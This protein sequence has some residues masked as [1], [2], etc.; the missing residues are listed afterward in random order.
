MKREVVLILTVVL[1]FALISQIYADEQTQVEQAYTC[2]S[3]RINQTGCSALSFEERA[4]SALASGECRSE[5]SADNS[6]NECW[7]KSGCTVKSTALAILALNSRV[8]TTKAE[9][10]LL[11]RTGTP[12]GIDW[13]LEIE[14]NDNSASSC[15]ITYPG[16]SPY[17]IKINQDKTIDKGAGNLLKRTPDHY[18]LQISPALYNKDI[19]ITCTDHSF[20]TTLLFK[21]SSYPTVHV[22]EQVHGAGKGGTTFERVESYCFVQGNSCTYEGSLWAALVLKSLGQDNPNSDISSFL[23]YLITMKDDPGNAIYIP[24]SFLYYLTAKFQEQLLI[25]QRVGGY[26][27]ESGNRYYDTALALLPFVY[28][29]SITAK[30]NAKTWLLANQQKTGCWNYG[31]I[32]DTAF[33]LF[34]IWP[35]D[36]SPILPVGVCE[37]DYDCPDISCQVASCSNEE[38]YYSDAGCEDYDGCCGQGCTNSNDNDC[39]SIACTNNSQCVDAGDPYSPNYCSGD[40]VYREAYTYHCDTSAHECAQTSNEEFVEACTDG[41][42]AGECNGGEEPECTT[43]LFGLSDS[44]PT[45]QECVEGKCV[46]KG[47]EDC[48]SGGDSACP[49]TQ[50][51][52]DYCSDDTT[53][54]RTAYSYS[55]DTSSG[56]CNAET[57]EEFVQTCNT[58]EICDGG[59]CVPNTQCECSLF[60]WCD[61]GY[62][63]DNCMCLPDNVSVECEDDSWCP[64]TDYG[65]DYCSDDSTAV[66]RSAHSYSCDTG[67]GKCVENVDEELVSTCIADSEICDN[68]ECITNQDV[69]SFWNWCDSGYHCDNGVCVPDGTNVDCEV[70]RDCPATYDGGDYCFDDQNVYKSVHSYSCDTSVGKCVEDVN[71]ELVSTCTADEYCDEGTAS[72][73]TEGTTCSIFNWCDSGFHCDSGICVPDGECEVDGDCPAQD[74][75]DSTC[76]SGTCLYEYFG[77][78][79]NDLCCNPGCNYTKDNDCPPGPECTSDLGCIDSNYQD[80]EYCGGSNSN[81][82][83]ITFHNYTCTN[84]VC[85]ESITDKLIEE[86]GGKECYFGICYGI[87][88]TCETDSDC[89][90]GEIC[91]SN[92]DC[93]TPTECTHSTDCGAKEDCIAGVCIPYECRA[94]SDCSSDEICSSGECVEKVECTSADD[95]GAKEECVGN[96]CIPYECRTNSDCS[97]DEIC[98]NE[99]CVPKVDCT[100]SS[101]CGTKAD[102]IGGVCIYYEC[103][104]DSD[105]FSGEICANEECVPKVTCTSSA[106]CNNK[107]DCTGGVCIPYECKTSDDCIYGEI[108]NSDEEC[109][110]STGC[111][112]YLDCDDY[113]NCIDGV[114]TPYTCQTELDC[115][116]GLC[117]NGECTG[118]TLLDCTDE[119]YYC[120]FQANCDDAQGNILSDYF[121]EGISECCDTQPTL[122]TC[123]EAGGEICNSSAKCVD[124][125][126]FEVS[127]NLYSGEACCIGG[128]CEIVSGTTDYCEEDYDGTCKDVCDSDEVEEAYTCDEGQTCCVPET[129]V[130]DDDG[131]CDAG[132]TKSNCSSDCKKGKGWILIVLLLILIIFAV[133]GIVFRDKLRT[134]WI[135]LKDKLGGKKEK[136]KFD[137]PTTMHPNP[138]GRILPRRIL[139]PGQG[140]QPMNSQL[141]QSRFPIRG[142]IPSSQ[143]PGQFRPQPGMPSQMGMAR[144]QPAGQPGAQPRQQLAQSGQQPGSTQQRTQQQPSAATPTK[145]AETEKSATVSK[146]GTTAK[147]EQ[148]EKIT[149]QQQ[150]EQQAKKPEDKKQEKSK[151]NELDE[152][153]KK[154]KEM[155]SK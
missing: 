119:G 133:L 152:V 79:N 128:T 50:Y 108:C 63:C 154:L 1:F 111:T 42:T 116:G 36:T 45:G 88:T 41:C 142:A 53:I 35:K 150:P 21:K 143:Y 92:G 120:T 121:C 49:E 101:D 68:G 34:S 60:N 39:P 96:V 130:C 113:E 105:C 90:S 10:W 26:W 71:E 5:L 85:K 66:Y 69:C 2:L 83:Y 33:V 28:D 141:A 139:P 115:D 135:K 82:V 62:S 138:Q 11:S 151:T 136:K 81:D 22:S 99:E 64:A 52:G 93:I 40:D 125:D 58:D 140:G 59:E 117:V 74:C 23:P 48:T 147:S 38:C 95:C 37:N 110:E 56:E 127:D 146:E 97:S 27:E 29:D 4:F 20:I 103:K 112:D 72:C 19:N 91:D 89:N 18:W 6:S 77:C 13:F 47:G 132:E 126:Y 104:A 76:E 8:N 7:P 145:P 57:N 98:A 70:D 73:I 155:G 102:C 51:G 15:T 124:G 153:L 114:C 30:T 137:M 109:V 43:G 94:D 12:S 80:S 54:Y 148:Q 123:D 86:C 144:P 78:E 149:K 44:C 14:I 131:V 106:D 61:S 100:S 134:Q 122:K 87:S 118:Q 107:E 9:K 65:G 67:L 46:D 32:R 31:N 25:K 16:Y 24:E 129:S 84:Q 3:T 75:Q 55:C 17:T